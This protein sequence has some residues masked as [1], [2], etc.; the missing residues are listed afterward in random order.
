MIKEDSISMYSDIHVLPQQ[1]EADGKIIQVEY[2][3]Q[4]E[5]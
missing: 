2:E 4:H 1:T 3:D 5:F